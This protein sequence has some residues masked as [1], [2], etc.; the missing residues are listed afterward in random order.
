MD[1][2]ALAALVNE[3]TVSYANDIVRMT[4]VDNLSPGG[5]EL[6]AREQ[7]GFDF[8]YVIP[9]PK[10]LEN[11]IPTI[12][13]TGFSTLDGSSKPGSST[14]PMLRVDQNMTWASNS[15]HSVKFGATFEHAQQNNADQIAFNQN[16]RFFFLDTGNPQGTGVAIANVALGVFN[17][18]DE[19]GPAADTRLRSN[20]VESYV[21]DTWKVS[22]KLTL[23]LG[24]RY[25]YHQPWYAKW[26]DISNF[27]PDF[28]QRANRAIV[29]R[30][31]GYI[32]SGDPYNGIVL[33]GDEFG[34]GAQAAG[35]P[36]IDRLFHGL[37]RGFTRASTNAFA[38]RFGMAYRLSE[39]TALR[40]GAGV[41]H[42]RQ[43][44]NSGALFR[45][46]PNQPRVDVA[47]G[48]VDNPG[49]GARRDVPAEP[50]RDRAGDE[51]PDWPTATASRCN[52]SCRS[53]W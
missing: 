7:Y 16:G 27:D 39:R 10:R 42:N 14:G 26:N 30:T 34:E 35:V 36:G 2:R 53:G 43:H 19:I 13:M 24:L 8:P 21:Q 1:E 45:N 6:W 46:A 50:G 15:T 20:S 5:Q 28:L 37:S 31:G 47:L 12:T 11:R 4:L 51:V 29:D 32:V 48:S 33:P 22:P 52:A 17:D 9:G 41:F 18:Y 49:G 40:L 44:H 3:F 25:A 23:E 38:P